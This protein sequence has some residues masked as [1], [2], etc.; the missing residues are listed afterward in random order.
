MAGDTHARSGRNGLL[1]AI[2]LGRLQDAGA[3]LTYGRASFGVW[4]AS[5]FVDLDLSPRLGGEISQHTSSIGSHRG[6]DLAGGQRFCQPICLAGPQVEGLRIVSLACPCSQRA[7]RVM[8]LGV[9]RGC[10]GV[11]LLHEAIDD[12]ARE[13]TGEGSGQ[14]RWAML[15]EQP[16]L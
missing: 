5:E 10:G 14:A 2:E 1:L 4:A 12:P 8:N 16:A 11:V 15:A 7:A 6:H 3:H 9:G 13:A